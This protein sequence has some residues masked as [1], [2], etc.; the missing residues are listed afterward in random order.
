VEITIDTWLYGELASYGGEADQGS[1]AH[2]KVVLTGDNTLRDLLA[3]LSLPTQERGITFI[4]GVLSASPNMQ[5][6]LEHMLRH[7]DRVAFFD[8][9]SMWPYQYRQGAAMTNELSS[10]L[11]TRHDQGMRNVT[12]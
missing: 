10:A 7:G 8:L 5:P 1:Y 6:D 3:K 4:N 2:L 9:H 11:D 12:K